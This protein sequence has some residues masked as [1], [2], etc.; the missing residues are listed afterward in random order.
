[1]PIKPHE[2]IKKRRTELGLSQEA[3]AE[4]VGVSRAAVG[5]WEKSPENGG[6]FPTQKHIL[7]L[8]AALRTTAGKV[9]I[10]RSFGVA[11]PESLSHFNLIPHISLQTITASNMEQLVAKASA[12]LDFSEKVDDA[13]AV[14]VLDESMA[15]T[16]QPGDEV[17]ARRSLYPQEGDIVVYA[18]SDGPAVLRKYHG[19][20]HGRSGEEVYDLV[21]IDPETP[22]V[23]VRSREEGH[24][25]GV[26]VELRKK[27]R[28]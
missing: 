1:M 6:S 2:F 4:L 14:T 24:I 25:V 17:V 21:A 3:L 12:F 22:T 7:A 15:P 16:Y 18:L 5:L 27:L 20:G 28:R 9:D 8:A 23:T 10:R 26:A 19:R 13:F 11:A